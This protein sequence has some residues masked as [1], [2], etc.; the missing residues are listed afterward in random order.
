M[1]NKYEL[2]YQKILKECISNGIYRDDRTGV[3][4][5]SLFDKHI[6]VNVSKQFP[7]IKGRKFSA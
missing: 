1:K 4:S 6:Q 7:I 2:Q 5:Y 3:G